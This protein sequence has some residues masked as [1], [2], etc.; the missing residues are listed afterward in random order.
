MHYDEFAVRP[1]EG[2]VERPL[3][4]DEVAR[5]QRWLYDHDGV[6]LKAPRLI[7]REDAHLATCELPGASVTHALPVLAP[8]GIADPAWV[9]IDDGDGALR[10]RREQ[11]DHLGDCGRAQV[12]IAA[13]LHDLRLDPVL[14]E[15]QQ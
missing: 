7:L 10:V 12:V 5:E 9:R 15:G 11:S 14:L 2:R 6:E 3:L 4:D 13:N 8:E 1:G